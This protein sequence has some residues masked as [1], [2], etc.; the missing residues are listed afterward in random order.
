MTPIVDHHD[1]NI[2]ADAPAQ[3]LRIVRAAVITLLIIMI[4][5][6][7]AGL[8][9]AHLDHGGGAMT[10]PMLA[11]LAALGIAAI[12][13]IFQLTR[14]VRG[15]FSNATQMPRRERASL[16]F[17]TV[18]LLVGAIIGGVTALLSA[19]TDWLVDGSGTFPP[20]LAIGATL[21]ILTVGPWIT[22]RWWKMIDEHEQRAYTDG[23]NVAG[24]FVLL[25][26]SA[27]WILSRAMLAPQPDVT[28]LLIGM[29]FVWTGVWLYRKYT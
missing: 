15:L 13:A 25:G 26:G 9:M 4:C 17:L 23:A 5:A 1:D 14:D 18:S 8:V 20:A 27:W 2:A 6:F 11:T 16:Q 10:I 21:V 7:G 22:L 29:S 3:S 19:E 12:A 24:H 28:V